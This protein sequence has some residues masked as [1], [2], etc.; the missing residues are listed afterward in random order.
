[1]SFFFFC[2]LV[3]KITAGPQLISIRCLINILFLSYETQSIRGHCESGAITVNTACSLLEWIFFCDYFAGSADRRL[4]ATL[5]PRKKKTFSTRSRQLYNVIIQYNLS[6]TLCQNRPTDH[7]SQSLCY[8]T[9]VPWTRQEIVKVSTRRK[10]ST[11][12]HRRPGHV[13][14]ESPPHGLRWINGMWNTGLVD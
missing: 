8:V 5:P 6:T 4:T 9:D 2:Y 7:R 3:N 14:S 1:M 10:R 13:G 12:R 11:P